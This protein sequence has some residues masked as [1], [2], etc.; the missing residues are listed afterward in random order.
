MIKSAHN[1]P[2]QRQKRNTGVQAASGVWPG[3]AGAYSLDGASVQVGGVVSERRGAEWRTPPYY[4]AAMNLT[5]QE[6][7]ILNH[8]W[9]K[10]GESVRIRTLWKE[11]N[12][13]RAFGGEKPYTYTTVATVAQNRRDKGAVENVGGWLDGYR[14]AS[15]ASSPP[16]AHAPQPGRRNRRY[17]SGRRPKSG[18]YPRP[19]AGGAAR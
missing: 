2:Q 12:Q 19:S 14:P 9:L 1:V 13:S 17:V 10:T 4:A 16:Y 18:P 11:F 7:D 8:M 3:A 5:E 6:V 15:N